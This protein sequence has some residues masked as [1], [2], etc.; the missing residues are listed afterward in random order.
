[1]AHQSLF[2]GIALPL[3][4]FGA[5]PLAPIFPLSGL[6]GIGFPLFTFDGCAFLAFSPCAEAV[7]R[8][9]L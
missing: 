7:A 3:G 6:F 5:V 1:M 9:H 2:G 8:L 4:S